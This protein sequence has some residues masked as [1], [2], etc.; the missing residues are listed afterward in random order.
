M[1]ISPVSG[2]PPQTA[3]ANNV[4]KATPFRRDK[5]GDYDNNRVET[6]QSESAEASKGGLVLNIK[7]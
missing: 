4:A 3:Q 2:S 6:K 7:A 5:D 1:S